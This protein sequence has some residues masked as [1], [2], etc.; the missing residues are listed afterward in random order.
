MLAIR[1]INSAKLR[2]LSHLLC[3]NTKSK[4]NKWQLSQIERPFN[5]PALVDLARN[6]QRKYHVDDHSNRGKSQFGPACG[7]RAD[8]VHHCA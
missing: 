2:P 5:E 4:Q 8:Q 3:I 1:K 6:Q 7:P